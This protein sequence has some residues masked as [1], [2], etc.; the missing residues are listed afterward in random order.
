MKM[1]N[2]WG[3][4]RHLIKWENW[5]KKNIRKLGVRVPGRP[6]ITASRH[7]NI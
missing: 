6:Q 1:E 2:Q 3:D 7:K 4:D 5:Y